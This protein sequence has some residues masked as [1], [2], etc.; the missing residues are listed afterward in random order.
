VR[1]RDTRA[2]YLGTFL[3]VRMFYCGDEGEGNAKDEDDEEKDCLRAGKRQA[4]LLL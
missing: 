2:L 1:G 3:E 4:H